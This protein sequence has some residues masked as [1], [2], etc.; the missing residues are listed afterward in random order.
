MKKL[1]K[2]FYKLYTYTHKTLPNTI[3]KCV[4]KDKNQA[5]A[6]LCIWAY[7]HIPSYDG[8]GC[9]FQCTEETIY[10]S[11]GSDTEELFSLAEFYDKR[12]R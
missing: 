5:N 7:N 11:D 8:F 9:A 12:N 6:L 10:V 2:N 1:D 3:F 4:A